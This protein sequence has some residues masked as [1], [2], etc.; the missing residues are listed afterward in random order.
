MC[1]CVC[2]CERE[3]ESVKVCVYVKER[4]RG[5]EGGGGEDLARAKCKRVKQLLL[6]VVQM[7]G[8]RP[9]MCDSTMIYSGDVPFWSETLKMEVE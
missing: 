8:F 4:Q 6:A 2:V 1:V 3:R 9:Q 5:G 7:E